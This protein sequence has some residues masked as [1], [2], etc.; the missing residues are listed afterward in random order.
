MLRLMQPSPHLPAD[1]PLLAY[2]YSESDKWTSAETELFHR[3]LLKLDKDFI[4]IA[5][6]VRLILTLCNYS[7]L[8]CVHI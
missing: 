7:S 6:E 3:C 4:R 2:S 5:E 8:I 1:H